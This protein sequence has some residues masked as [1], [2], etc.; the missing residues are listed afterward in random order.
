MKPE[1]NRREM[2]GALAGAA[3]LLGAAPSLLGA[4]ESNRKRLGIGIYSYGI[5]GKAARDGHPKARFKDTLEFIEYCHQIGAGGVQI[6][7]GSKESAYAA[8]VRHKIESLNMYYEGQT[9]L[10]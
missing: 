3:T 1:M 8:Q 6:A 4:D 9:G 10:P 5:H 2:L 7:V